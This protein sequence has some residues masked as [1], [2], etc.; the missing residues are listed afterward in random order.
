MW[1]LWPAKS[2]GV[3][4]AVEHV[5][6]RQLINEIVVVEYTAYQKLQ[7]EVERIDKAN[8]EELDKNY[9]LQAKL[10]AALQVVT[11]AAEYISEFYGDSHDL[12]SK[13]SIMVSV[14]AAYDGTKP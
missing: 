14:L 12:A 8:D 10:T 11:A 5:G 3:F 6:E 7:A 1:T 4:E 9:K 13:R 2:Y